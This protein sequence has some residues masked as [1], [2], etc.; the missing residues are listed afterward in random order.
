NAAGLAHITQQLLLLSRSGEIDIVQAPCP[1]APLL[2]QAQLEAQ[3]RAA[4][5]QLAI[6]ATVE[7]PD[8]ALTIVGDA[9]WIN[10][11]LRTATRNA[12]DALSLD[13]EGRL[14]LRALA[15]DAAITIQIAD[16]GPGFTPAQLAQLDPQRVAS[17]DILRWTTKMGG[18]GI[19]IACLVH[20][21]RLHHGQVVFANAPGG[22]AL[23]SL[24]F[25]RPE[26]AR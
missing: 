18:S 5:H 24:I 25:A 7:I 17:G 1:V 2:V 19:G 22:G 13:G 23:V 16:T 8:E 11:A 6:S 15:T 21:M 4:A 14:T 12:F 26:A 20:V 10:L 3:S 9:Q